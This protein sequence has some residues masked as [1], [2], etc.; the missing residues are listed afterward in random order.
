MRFWT[1][2]QTIYNNME[3]KLKEIKA[4]I[5]AK[6]QELKGEFCPEYFEYCIASLYDYVGYLERSIGNLQERLYDHTS[7]G[8]L[9]PIKSAGQLEKA[10]KVLGIGDDYQVVKPVI[11]AKKREIEVTYDQE[12]KF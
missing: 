4:N 2:Y 7:N 5:E 11:W 10:I 3:S 8:H 6:K 12:N 1:D 9:P